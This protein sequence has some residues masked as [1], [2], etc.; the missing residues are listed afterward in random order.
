M[1]EDSVLRLEDLLVHDHAVPQDRETELNLEELEK[2]AIRQA[3]SKHGGNLSKAA[4]ELGL[5][6]TTLYRKMAKHEI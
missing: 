5:G 6:R 3:I 1:A 4:Q 2:A